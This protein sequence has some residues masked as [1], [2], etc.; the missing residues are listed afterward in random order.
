MENHHDNEN[1]L[2]NPLD[3]RGVTVASPRGDPQGTV[4]EGNLG[5]RDVLETAT[6]SGD[7]GNTPIPI[8]ALADNSV[9]MG[10][11]ES[12]L[13]M[14]ST[15]SIGYNAPLELT[16]KRDRANPAGS[17]S[18]CSAD[19]QIHMGNKARDPDTAGNPGEPVP[20]HNIVVPH[21]TVVAP[22]AVSAAPDYIATD[23]QIRA[24]I[25]L[26]EIGSTANLQ[27]ERGTAVTLNLVQSRT[28]YS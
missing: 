5:L 2:R 8:I 15:P 10:G 1:T 25:C 18:I 20:P 23:S 21:N 9:S 7:S 22:T 3:N 27:P 6:N 16:E 4:G 19:P 17:S 26:E 14:L 13:P 12:L 11:S 28:S 24:S